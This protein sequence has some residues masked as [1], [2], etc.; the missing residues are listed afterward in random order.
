MRVAR[1]GWI[2]VGL[3]LFLMLVIGAFA[4]FFPLDFT[5]AVPGQIEYGT[6]LP[7]A[8]PYDG[9]VVE[10]APTGPVAKGA[11]LLQVDDGKEQG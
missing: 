10:I 11:L 6:V 3:V 9:H 5:T 8:C 7:V 2:S 4:A 1:L